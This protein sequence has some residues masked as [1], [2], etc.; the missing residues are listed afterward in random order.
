MLQLDW[1]PFNRID[2][3]EISEITGLDMLR[4]TGG[5]PV[6]C[7]QHGGFM[8]RARRRWGLLVIGCAAALAGPQFA[9]IGQVSA[10]DYIGTTSGSDWSIPSNWSAG[11]PS[12]A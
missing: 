5:P 8:S 12:G 6:K 7:R 9:G 10:S 4:S 11:V 1:A 2:Y 3:A